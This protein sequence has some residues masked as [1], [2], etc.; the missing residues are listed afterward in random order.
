MNQDIE[1]TLRA[2]VAA[3]VRPAGAVALGQ[4]ERPWPVVLLTALG[5][6]LAAL[7]GVLGVMLG[8]LLREGAGCYVVGVIAL[9]GAM[10]VLRL[11]EAPL[12]VEQLA[13][14]ALLVGGGALAYALYR[15]L[16]G[17]GASS[18]VAV[19][20]LAVGAALPHSWLRVLLGAAAAL[21]T[22]LACVLSAEGLLGPWQ[23]AVWWLAW[24]AC[25]ALWRVAGAEQRQTFNDGAGAPVAAALESM[26]A[27]WMLTTL[28]GL[29]GWSGMTMFVGASAGGGLVADVARQPFSSWSSAVLSAGSVILTLAAALAFVRTWPTLRRPWCGALWPGSCQ[30]WAAPCW[31][32]PGAP[33]AGAGAWRVQPRWRWPGSWAPST[34]SCTGR[35]PPRPR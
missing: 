23:L 22:V 24:H 35:W 12:F 8:G 19:L 28:A 14:P 29:A 30:R 15:D 11:R 10:A 31:R 34:T 1:R 26:G 21:F 32:W 6:W 17:A 9:L 20:A 4:D 33:P 5:A 16:P 18:G 3:G 7:L 25:L 13:V 2:A 27:G